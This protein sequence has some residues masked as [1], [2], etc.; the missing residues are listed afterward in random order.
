M[1]TKHYIRTQRFCGPAVLRLSAA[2][3]DP[4]T[5]YRRLPSSSDNS[6]EEQV[7]GD[8]RDL[9]GFA[10]HLLQVRQFAF[11]RAVGGQY[12][13]ELG[14]LVLVR[15]GERTSMRTAAAASC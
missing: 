10:P 2:R 7:V 5:V 15:V 14:D 11:K 9:L 4:C 13:G 3:I 8:R 12:A 6:G 1:T